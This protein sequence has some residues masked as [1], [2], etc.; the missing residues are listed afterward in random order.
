MVL[1]I[2]CGNTSIKF[3]IVENEKLKKSYLIRTISEKSDDE[4]AY[5]FASLLKNEKMIDG[6]IISSVVPLLTPVLFSAIK[7]VYGIEAL[8]VGKNIKTKLALK[9]DN[10]AELGADMIAGAVGAKKKYGAST[11]VADLG[12]ATKI[13]I[14]NKDEAFSGCI[15]TC[16]MEIGLKSLVSSTSQ[17]LETPIIVP[18]KILGKNTKECI[19]SGIVYGQIYMINE[20][21]KRIENELGYPLK[22]VLTGGYSKIIKGE[23]NSFIYD[24]DLILDGLYHIFKINEGDLYE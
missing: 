11:L 9:I 13:Y 10:P 5:S 8:I 7:K 12:T 19:Q 14:V 4:Y 15:I 24:E 22:K 1:C 2:D 16:G 21:A 3:G 6:A 20:F 23:L 18:P 17:L